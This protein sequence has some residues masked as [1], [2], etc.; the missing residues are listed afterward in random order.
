[1]TTSE[2]EYYL[3]SEL[4]GMPNRV[5]AQQIELLI[6]NKSPIPN[7]PILEKFLEILRES[8]GSEEF[9]EMSEK[10]ISGIGGIKW[11][12]S[13]TDSEGKVNKIKDGANYSACPWFLVTVSRQPI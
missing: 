6:W 5:L 12:C 11:H 9:Y 1:M 3:L 10:Y 13:M 4:I 2:F 8:E 7:E